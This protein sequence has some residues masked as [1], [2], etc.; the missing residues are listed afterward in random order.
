[1]SMAYLASMKSK[2]PSSRIGAI[3]VDENNHLISEGFNGFPRGVEDSEERYSNREIKYAMVSHGERNAIYAAANKGFSLK[4]CRIYTQGTP[5]CDCC[6][7]IIQSGISEVI[8]D[9]RWEE[10]PKNIGNRAK[11]S[12]ESE[13]SKQMFKESRITIRLYDG[14]LISQ[15]K[16]L[17]SG[18]EFLC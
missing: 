15:I 17:Y 14:P 11:W 12:A 10:M 5:C 3:I 9:S 18:K 1:M 6:K 13:I 16:G 4:G 8:V 7:A 2:D